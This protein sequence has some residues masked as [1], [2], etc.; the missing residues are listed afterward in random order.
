[1]KVRPLGITLLALLFIILG[2]ASFLWSLMQFGFGGISS[3]FNSLFSLSMS[4]DASVWTGLLGMATAGVQ[5]AAGIG[6][7]R[8]K[9]WAWYLALIAVGFSVLS[10]IVGMFSGGLFV[11]FCG[12]LGILIPGAILFYLLQPRIRALFDIGAWT[13]VL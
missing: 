10:G 1:M 13:A 7:L 3:F 8:L 2:G 6:L 12:C 4:V 11:F 5:L 9:S